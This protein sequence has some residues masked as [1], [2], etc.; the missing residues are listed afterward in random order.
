MRVMPARVS[1]TGNVSVFLG[2]SYGITK[3]ETM[4]YDERGNLYIGDNVDD[5]LYMVSRDMKLNRVI[6]K[7]D[8]FSPE[9][10]LYARNALYI[11]EHVR[12]RLARHVPNLESSILK[13][14]ALGPHD[15]QRANVKLMVEYQRDL[16]EGDNHSLNALLRFAF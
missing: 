8:T 3:P 14:V 15:L 13:R 10:I 12:A 9:G 11:T 4:T 2:T 1:R 16:R 6:E 7:R 5:V